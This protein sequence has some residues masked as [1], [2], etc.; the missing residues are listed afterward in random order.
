MSHIGFIGVGKMGTPMAH[1]LLKSGH[2]VK[3][4]DLSS[5]ALD[6]VVE[7]GALVANSPSDAAA[8]VDFVITM[9]PTGKEVRDI[10]MS[11]ELLGKANHNTVFIDCSTIDVESSL[12]VHA[13]VKKAGFNMID[14]PVSGGTAGA[15]KA[16][17]TFMCGGEKKIFKKCQEIFEGM[18]KNIVHCGGPSQGQAVKICNNMVAGTIFLATAEAFVLGEK[19]GVDRETIFDVISTSTGN[20]WVLENAC[21]LPGGK[22]GSGGSKDFK[23]GFSAQLMLK[24]LRLSQ[25]AAEMA[26]SSTPLGATATTAYQQH[27]NNG[28][29]QLDTAS[30]CL[31]INP[32]IE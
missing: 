23:P 27:V 16:T 29:G 32:E 13:T 11:S 12:A 22:P 20:S 24:D 26:S 7:K 6:S 17:L 3:V 9:L 31:L 25:A 1:N 14:A 10:F 28:Y 15:E 5:E 19:L 4:F 30:I 18:G 8:G 21:P 2:S